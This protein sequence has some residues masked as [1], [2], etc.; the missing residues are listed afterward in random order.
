MDPCTITQSHAISS[1]RWQSASMRSSVAAAPIA[2][3]EAL[4]R[5]LR[6]PR[7]SVRRQRAR[8]PGSIQGAR[9]GVS[10]RPAPGATGRHSADAAAQRGPGHAGRSGASCILRPGLPTPPRLD[11]AREGG[12][13]GVACRHAQAGR[14]AP[15]PDKAPSR[16]TSTSAQSTRQGARGARAGTGGTLRCARGTPGPASW[17]SGPPHAPPEKAC[18]IARPCPHAVRSARETHAE[19]TVVRLGTPAYRGGGSPSVR[20]RSARC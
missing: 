17:S 2:P 19:A 11:Q 14:H 18:A 6:G 12:P 8:H 4:R 7:P 10:P 5:P 3:R 16:G 9:L 1:H 13:P 20:R 15:H